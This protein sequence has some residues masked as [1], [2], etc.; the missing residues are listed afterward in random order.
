MVNEG[1]SFLRV[2]G[3]NAVPSTVKG[4][5]GDDSLV[6]RLYNPS[7]EAT[8]ARLN[9]AW[10]IERAE[11]VNLNEEPLG[12]ALPVAEGHQVLVPLDPKQIVTVKATPALGR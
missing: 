8:S 10:E 4:A 3:R 11:R 12:E 6:V 5:E 1:L 7:E 9:F 2:E